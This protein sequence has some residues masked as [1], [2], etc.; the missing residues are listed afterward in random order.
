[1]EATGLWSLMET[2]GG[3]TTHGSQE[4]QPANI[5]SHF[6]SGCRSVRFS[7]KI[8]RASMTMTMTMTPTELRVLR[9][10]GRTLEEPN[11]KSLKVKVSPVQRPY[12]GQDTLT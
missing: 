7:L 6:G 12:R 2:T 9:D 11:I 8:Y 1:M 5:H 4:V 3:M 10:G